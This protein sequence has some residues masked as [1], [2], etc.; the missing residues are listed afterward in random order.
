MNMAQWKLHEIVWTEGEEK[1][2]AWKIR[3]NKLQKSGKFET[4]YGDYFMC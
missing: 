1:G 4:A 2:L 3:Q